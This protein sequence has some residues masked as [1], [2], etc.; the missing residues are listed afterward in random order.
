MNIPLLLAALSLV[1]TGNDDRAIGGDGEVSR[2][3]LRRSVWAEHCKSES[4]TNPVTATK[5]A[6][7]VLRQRIA[8]F[9]RRTGRLP[10]PADVYA[11]WNSPTAFTMSQYRLPYCSKI[12]QDKAG[13]FAN[14]VN[15]LLLGQ[16][17]DDAPL[18]K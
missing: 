14:V 12:L 3:Q 8:T 15:A 16:I 11:M 13:R 1:E 7:L 2:Y 10:K 6:T 18:D 5:V 4:W 17:K 9:E